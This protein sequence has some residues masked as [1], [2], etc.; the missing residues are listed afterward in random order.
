MSGWVRHGW[1]EPP[2]PLNRASSALLTLCLSLCFAVSR[3]RRPRR[4]TKYPPSSSRLVR[5]PSRLDDADEAALRRPD[6]G[7]RDRRRDS[8]L[9]GLPSLPVRFARHRR[10][11]SICTP[12]TRPSR[13]QVGATGPAT[14]TMVKQDDTSPASRT[15]RTRSSTIDTI[16]TGRPAKKARSFKRSKSPK[17]KS[18][19]PLQQ[20]PREDRGN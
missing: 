14:T 17:L 3:S 15:R 10:D 16:T 8:H 11:I 20:R 13:A 1:R 7:R 12:S 5:S 18:L 9:R 4:R 6:H 19:R 2:P